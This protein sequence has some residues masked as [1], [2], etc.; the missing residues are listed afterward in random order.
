MV[1]HSSGEIAA[2]YCVG[3]ISRESAWAVSYFRGIVAAKLAM[4]SLE[5][6]GSMISV[7]LSELDLKPYIEQLSLQGTIAVGCVNSPRSTTITGDEKLVDALKTIMDERKIFAR[8]LAVDVAYH[9]AQMNG[10]ADEYQI[11][12]KNRL[13]PRSYSCTLP[14]PT[15]HSSITGRR[16]SN[17][18]LRESAYWVSN[19]IS[20]VEFS[21]ALLN[22]CQAKESK[23]ISADRSTT[24]AID[25]LVEIGPHS[26]LRRIVKDTVRTEISYSSVLERNTSALNSA[27][28]FAGRLHSCGYIVNLMAVN[29][30]TQASTAL[31]ML[32]T[33][34][35]Y[36]FNHSLSYWHESRISKNFRFRPTPRHELLGTRSTDWNHSEAKWRNV[37]KRSESPWI[38]HHKFGDNELYPGAGMIVMAVEAGRQLASKPTEI[39]GYR[40]EDVHF[41]NALILPTNSEYVETHFYLR[42]RKGN[43]TCPEWSEFG[44]YVYLENEWME[45]CRGRLMIEYK[46]SANEVNSVYENEQN[47]KRLKDTY[48]S[49]AKSCGVTIDSKRLYENFASFGFHF[50]PTFQTLKEVSYGDDGECTGMCYLREWRTKVPEGTGNIQ[51]HVIHPTGLD[52]VFHLPLVGLTKGGWKQVP[53]VVPTLARKLWVS[54]D[55]LTQPDLQSVKA[56]S[57]V[58]WTGYR[59]IESDTVA[60]N[61]MTDEPLI[62]VEACRGT[63]VGSLD[64]YSW[65]RLCFHITWKPDLDMLDSEQ[66]SAYCGRGSNR[67]HF[68]LHDIVDTCEFACLYFLWVANEAVSEKERTNLSNS[69]GKYIAWMGHY[70]S[71]DQS[72]ALLSSPEMSRL[73]DDE[74]Y[75]ER[76]LH[77]LENSSV[78]GKLIVSVGRHLI[79]ILRGE[80]D[81]LSFLFEGSLMKDFYNGA[82]YRLSYQKAAAYVDLLAHK[83]PN[84]CILEIGAGTGGMTQEVLDTLR[85]RNQPHKTITPR[86]EQ[87][88]YTDISSG[89]F[90]EAKKRFSDHGDRLIFKPLDIETDPLVQ[91][92]EA[93]KYDLVIASCV[94]HATENM[95]V[96]LAHTRNILKPGGKLVL[97]E[98]C[99]LYSSRIPFVFGL[100]PGWWRGTEKHRSLGPLLSEETWRETLSRNGYSGADICLSDFDPRRSTFNVIVAT[101]LDINPSSV[102]IP[103]TLIITSENSRL[104]SQVSQDL[105]TQLQLLEIGSCQITNSREMR[106]KDLERTFCIFLP[107]LEEPYLKNIGDEDFNDLKHIVKNAKGIIWVTN[108]ESPISKTPE[109]GLATGFARS[110]R[111]EDNNFSFVTLALEMAEPAEKAVAS[112]ITVYQAAISAPHEQIESEY[113]VQRGILCINRIVDAAGPSDA[114]FSKLAQKEPELSSFGREPERALSLTIGS[115][116]LLN[117]LHFVDDDG[118]AKPLGTNELRVKVKAVGVNFKDVMIALG[119]LP[120]KSLGQECAGIVTQ[121]GESVDPAQLK[122]GDRVCC[123]VNGAFKTYALSQASATF[124][125]P[126]EMPFPVAASLP[127]VFCTSYYALFHLA[128]LKRGESIMIHSAAGGVGQAAVQLAKLVEA[129][130][131]V[132]VGTEEKKKL[133]MERYNIQEDH[134]FFS[135]NTSFAQGVKRMTNYRGVDVILNSLAGE[136]LRQSFECIAPLGRFIEIGKKD[137]HTGESLSMSPFL[138]SVTF[139]SVD[140]SVVADHAP[141]LIAELMKTVISLG[142]TE[143]AKIHPPWPLNNFK[144]SQVEEAFRYLQTGKNVGKAVVELNT[145]DVVLVSSTHSFFATMGN[146]GTIT[147]R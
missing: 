6:P 25:Y 132:T 112:I 122:P 125:I 46:N 133:L 116:G 2:A 103:N 143:P 89:F 84:L 126:D 127:I 88:T 71:Q 124:K 13:Q 96:T 32:T 105:K 21:D 110:I 41:P 43:S 146:S 28:D 113:M 5:H 91:G 106:S 29:F 51:P 147:Y 64:A 47:R 136:S 37:I 59:E 79:G 129:D 117:T 57:K 145:D 26:S 15:M 62:V 63:T 128:R 86:Y 131:Y 77:N 76:Y 48:I 30:P 66:L 138:K 4:R 22:M 36:P 67:I 72:Q 81:T 40:F 74:Q 102:T 119:Q 82:V 135:R 80:I 65:R 121:V 27:L 87:Y 140:L 73:M 100:L 35:E 142:S 24:S 90:E 144:V 17:G 23:Q 94:L 56:Y 54:N 34:P 11:L 9:S 92:F 38:S 83:N 19:L 60:L 104:Q 78:E 45:T 111:S 95:D 52:S 85:P 108:N 115:L 101:A 107:E 42:S 58:R 16:I 134:V 8:K 93:G 33:L 3:G 114:V 10:L 120:G 20:K 18:K 109:M 75:R 118:A 70:F 49:G 1:G 97:V 137:M 14:L 7:A 141:A 139:A 99:N 53:V 55:F 68:D 12:I 98:S 123:V 44:L 31:E 50:G 39:N 130:I 61:A 69:H